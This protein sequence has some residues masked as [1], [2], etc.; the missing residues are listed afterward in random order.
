MMAV[1]ERIVRSGRSATFM[2]H[3][4][5]TACDVPRVEIERLETVPLD[6]DVNEQHVAPARILE[7]IGAEGRS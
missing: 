3:L 6:A 7:L 1:P 2:D 4:L 5:S